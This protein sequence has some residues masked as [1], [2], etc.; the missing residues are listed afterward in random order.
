[1][2]KGIQ[3]FE[4]SPVLELDTL[5]D[6]YHHGL[7][8]VGV[9]FSLWHNELGR[10]NQSTSTCFFNEGKQGHPVAVSRP[11]DLLLGIIERILAAE[12]VDY[13]QSLRCY[14]SWET[15]KTT[16]PPMELRWLV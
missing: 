8:S 9:S 13:L 11:L 2:D 3:L 16:D 6:E 10:L 5:K 14:V 15:E 7:R 4:V 12:W 1:M